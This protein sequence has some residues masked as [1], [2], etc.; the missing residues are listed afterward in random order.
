MTGELDDDRAELLACLQY[1]RSAV[2]SI[3]RGLSE[4]A[5]HTS[6][7][8]SGWTPAGFVEH[9]GGAEYYWFHN[10]VAGLPDAEPPEGEEPTPFDRFAPF[11][12]DSSSTE[13]VAFYTEQCRVSDEILANVAM[14]TRPLGRHT[15]DEAVPSVRWVVLHM[16]EETAAHSGHLEIARELLDGGVRLGQ[17]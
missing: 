4:D 7:V 9:L 13:I 5:W 12:S 15:L 3:V 11:T 6:V 2:L 14:S 10:V 17:R 16:I 1:Q 8:P